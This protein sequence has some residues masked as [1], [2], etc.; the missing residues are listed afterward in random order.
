MARRLW[1]IGFSLAAI[2][3]LSLVA[4]AATA[5]LPRDTVVPL[6]EVTKYFPDVTT[7]AGTGLNET[8]I[9]SPAASLSVVFTSADGTKK[10][11]LSVDQ[12]GSADEATA[13]FNTAVEGSKDA[14]GFK[15]SDVPSLG[16]A[17]FAGTSQVGDEKHFGLG[18]LDGRLIISATHAGAIPVT[19]ENAENLIALTA[20]ELSLAKQALGN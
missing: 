12:Y 14:P 13:A 10:V 16:Q 3:L 18:A 9:G 15:P 5:L 1:T 17:A 4:V 19:P 6:S 8:Q 20:T 2:A 11:T 7:E